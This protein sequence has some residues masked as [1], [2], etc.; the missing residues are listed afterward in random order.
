MTTAIGLTDLEALHADLGVELENAARRVMRSG[1]FILG[2]EVEAFERELAGEL[3]IPL[4][5]GVSSGTDALVAILHALDVGAGDEVIT[6]PFSFFATVEAIVRVGAK[7]VFADIDPATLNLDP[8]AAAARICERTAAVVVV[9]LFG[10][11]AGSAPLAQACASAGVPLVEDAAQ[12]IGA[13]GRDG[14]TAGAIGAAAAL[15]FFPSKNLGGFGD[16]GA[17]LTATPTLAARVRALRSHGASRPHWHDEIGGNYRMDELQAALLRVKLPRLSA[18]TARRRAVAALYGASWKDL[19]LRL[20]PPDAGSVW[21]QFVVRLPDGG[22][23]ALADHLRRQGIATAV[24]YPAPLH[25]QPALSTYGGRKGQLPEAEQAASEV[26]ALP[27]HPSLT[28]SEVERI[29]EAVRGF[30][31]GAGR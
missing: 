18:W 27:I 9:H 19:P 29:C 31:V 7:P 14:R 16:S 6:T 17:V 20:P 1:R 22:R 13:S 28:S 3:G 10:R 30:F 23:D 15:S 26:L 4:A 24:Y 25:L 2:P 5:V 11:I 12:A 8:S 21:N